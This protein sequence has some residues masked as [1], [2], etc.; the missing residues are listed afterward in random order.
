MRSLAGFR[1]G[2]LGRGRWIV[3]AKST[4]TG[5]GPGPAIRGAVD[6]PDR[7]R[8]ETPYGNFRS[9]VSCTQIHALPRGR[10]SAPSE[11]RW[12]VVAIERRR[13]G[14]RAVV[15][16]VVLAG[17]VASLAACAP[18]TT[19]GAGEQTPSQSQSDQIASPSESEPTITPSDD[20]IVDPVQETRRTG[21]SV[22]IGGPPSG[23]QGLEDLGDGRWC[24]GIALFWGSGSEGVPEG[25]TFTVEG[26]TSN[27]EGVVLGDDQEVCG[28]FGAEHGCI[29]FPLTYDTVNIFCTLVLEPTADF[30]NGTV[31]GLAG[32]LD[33]P[34]KEVCDAMATREIE[35]GPPIVICDPAFTDAGNACVPV[36]SHE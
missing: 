12:M 25:V 36:E 34:T 14:L 20:V 21:P 2:A 4:S 29:G 33:C 24:E 19:E 27:P 32:T 1:A 8:Y 18:T 6:Q 11:R 23:G 31:L 16:A 3:A 28:Q 10:P 30:V 35:Q 15:L 17:S 22:D 9:G 5:P 26:I 13:R 7:L